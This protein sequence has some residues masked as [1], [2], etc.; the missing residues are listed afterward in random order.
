MSFSRFSR[1]VPARR[2]I[3]TYCRCSA[4]SAVSQRRSAIPVL[5]GDRVGTFRELLHLCDGDLAV[6]WMNKIQERTAAELIGGEAK[7]S[8]PSRIDALEIAC[9]IRNAEHIERVVKELIEDLFGPLPFSDL[10]L[11]FGNEVA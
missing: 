1:L 3:L 5:E 8:F 2:K 10:Q 6:V 11:Q 4:L 7:R 9:K